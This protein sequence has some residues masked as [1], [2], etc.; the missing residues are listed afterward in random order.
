MVPKSTNTMYFDWDNAGYHF[1]TTGD[2]C[3]TVTSHAPRFVSDLTQ[4]ILGKSPKALSLA[5]VH[6]G[7]AKIIRSLMDAL[8]IHGSDSEALS[9]ESMSGANDTSI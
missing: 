1:C 9:W 6:T 3:N 4:G 7:G 8:Q 5:I 2:V